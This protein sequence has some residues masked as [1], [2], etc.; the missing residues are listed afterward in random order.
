MLKQLK[1]I[2]S[3]GSNGN[4]HGE[5]KIKKVKTEKAMGCCDINTTHFDLI[6]I[7]GGSAAFAAAIKANE[8]GMTTLMVNGGLPIGGTCVNVGCLPSKYLI[9]AAETIHHASHSAFDGIKPNK[10]SWDYKKIIQ[11]KK[12][13]VKVMQQ[14]KYLDVVSDFETLKIVEGIAEFVDEKTIIVNKKDAYTAKNF[15]IAT[16]STTSIP[17]VEGLDKVP[18]YTNDTL[19]DI[20]E[21]PE[22]LVIIGG[23]YIGLEIAQAYH[24]F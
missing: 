7:G 21:L 15:L 8:S 4:L 22:S 3:S 6:I 5:T 17:P 12:E 23:G 10:P 19:L 24:R 9:R 13:L 11:Q 18:Y 2:F 20:E 14:K 1:N 16:G